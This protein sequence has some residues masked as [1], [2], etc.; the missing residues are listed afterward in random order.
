MTSDQQFR[1]LLRFWNCH[2]D[3][4]REGADVATLWASHQRLERARRDLRAA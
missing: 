2:Q 3:L 1:T 4:R